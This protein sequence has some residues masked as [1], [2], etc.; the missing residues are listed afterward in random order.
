MRVIEFIKLEKMTENSICLIRIYFS[1]VLTIRVFSLKAG[2]HCYLSNSHYAINGRD[3][4]SC[5]TFL[6]AYGSLAA[7]EGRKIVA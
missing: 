5:V 6:R 4:R 3:A 2:K 1:I 7:N